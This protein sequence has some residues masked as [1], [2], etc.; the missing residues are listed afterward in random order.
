MSEDVLIFSVPPF[1][2]AYWRGP[3]ELVRNGRKALIEEVWDDSAG[4]T[5]PVHIRVWNE[6]EQDLL[7]VTIWVPAG[8][9]ESNPLGLYL[10]ETQTLFL[11]AGQTIVVYSL[12]TPRHM[13]YV[14]VFFNEYGRWFRCDDVV[15]YDCGYE[16]IAFDSAGRNLWKTNYEMGDEI[17][18]CDNKLEIVRDG[19]VTL[20]DP[21]LRPPNLI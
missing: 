7:H 14:R 2:F 12:Q 20:F 13:G 17:N 19:D 11:S 10:S 3:A 9:R 1:H 6:S 8:L 5:R 18:V 15:L 4:S 16:L 21:H